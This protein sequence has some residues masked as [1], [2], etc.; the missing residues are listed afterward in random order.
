MPLPSRRFTPASPSAPPRRDG[1]AIKA[2]RA[3]RRAATGAPHPP[4]P[5]LLYKRG[6]RAALHAHKLHRR[7]PTPL[8]SRSAAAKA[9]SA[10]HRSP[11][12]PDLPAPPRPEVRWGIEPP[13]SPLPLAP[14]LGRRRPPLRRH[15]DRRR[16]LTAAAV[17]PHPAGPLSPN[18]RGESAPRVSL[19]H[20]PSPR[21]APGPDR[22]PRAVA[23]DAPSPSL[24]P[25]VRGGRRQGIL[26]IT[27]WPFL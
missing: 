19:S 11:P 4:P 3:A 17:N 20:F 23:G 10:G 16:L 22:R 15:H 27:P 24:F 18:Q 21:A 8:Q 9:A 7:P 14:I 26:P 6:P 12:R 25:S 1:D 5:R 13:R 2:P